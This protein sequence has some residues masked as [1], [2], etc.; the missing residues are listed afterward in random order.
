MSAIIMLERMIK[1]RP[2]RNTSSLFNI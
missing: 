2:F 1:L